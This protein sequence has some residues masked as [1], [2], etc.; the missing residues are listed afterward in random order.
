MASGPAI[1]LFDG[2]CAFCEGSVKFIARRDPTGYFRF[3][4]S[5]SPSRVALLAQH[6]LS[7]DST[8]SI[9]LLEDGEVYVQSTASLRIARRCPFRGRWQGR[10][11]VPRPLR[12]AYRGVAAIRHRLAAGRRMPARSRR[13]RFAHV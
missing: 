10:C 5:Q 11:V 12:D 4:A 7:R 3:G 2:T 6:G 9:V 13:R 1:V 8:R